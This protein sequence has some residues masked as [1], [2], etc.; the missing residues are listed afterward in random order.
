MQRGGVEQ[1]RRARV[2]P[3]HRGLHGIGKGN[4]RWGWD[5]DRAD[6]RSFVVVFETPAFVNE[7][8]ELHARA[9]IVARPRGKQ[10]HSPTF[11]G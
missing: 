9:C 11:P 7:Q 6:H 8:G 10:V 5:K 2:E 4:Q 1:K 3:S